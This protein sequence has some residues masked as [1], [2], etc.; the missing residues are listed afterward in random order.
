MK[1]KKKRDREKKVSVLSSIALAWS[2]LF[3]TTAG[4]CERQTD[5]Q[6]ERVFSSG[7]SHPVPSYRH[8]DVKGYVVPFCSLC[9]T[10]KIIS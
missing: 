9:K 8:L 5:R 10:K 2:L 1:R 7:S 4:G 3:T 6:T